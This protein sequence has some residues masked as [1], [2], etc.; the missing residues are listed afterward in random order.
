MKSKVQMPVLQKKRLVTVGKDVRQG[1]TYFALL[2]VMG[3][4]HVAHVLSVTD[5]VLH[6]VNALTVGIDHLQTTILTTNLHVAVEPTKKAVVKKSKLALTPQVKDEQNANVLKKCGHVP[7]SAVVMGA[8]MSMEEEKP[9]TFCVPK[10]ETL[11]AP[12]AHR[13]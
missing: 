9:A 2:E 12:Q 4:R 6:S 3:R 1:K 8:A 11:N 7:I 13:V 5:V 10:K